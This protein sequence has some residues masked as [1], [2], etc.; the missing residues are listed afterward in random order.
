MIEITY[1]SLRTHNRDPISSFVINLV[2]C[3]L[4]T[5]WNNWHRQKISAPYLMIKLRKIG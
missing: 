4:R 3:D 2:A 5:I 1:L